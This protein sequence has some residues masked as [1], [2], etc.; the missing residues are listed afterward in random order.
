MQRTDFDAIAI[1]GGLA[2]CAFAIPLAR[3]GLRVAVIER[4]AQAKLKVCGDFLSAEAQDLLSD[5]EIDV[6][7][8]GAQ[9]ISEFRMTSGTRAANAPLPFCAAGVSRLALDEA[10]LQKAADLGIELIRGDSV[11]S[12][13]QAPSGIAVSVGGK[14]YTAKAAAL[15]TGKHN[16]RGYPRPN[17]TMAA[18]KMSFELTAAANALLS[19]RVQLSGFEGGYIGASLIEDGAATLCW[20]ADPTF[21]SRTNGRW[22]AQLDGLAKASPYVGDLL[23]GA[24][25]LFGQPATTAAIPYGFRRRNAVGASFFPVGDQLSVIPSFTGNGTSIALSSG[26]AAAKAFLRG[27]AAESFQHAFLRRLA[28]QF[29]WANAIDIAFKSGVSRFIGVAAIGLFPA[30]ATQLTRLTRL[31]DPVDA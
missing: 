13:E 3:A 27:E 24:K 6:W 29:R 12:V 26:V 23:S 4:T 30:L 11:T 10:L 14:T 28:P 15:A 2:G 22:Q 8:I 17:G 16:L 21:M 25:P 7:Q 20:V 1:G 5:F 19:R 9:P 31:A 18:F